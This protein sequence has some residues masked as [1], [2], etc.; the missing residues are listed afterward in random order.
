NHQSTAFSVLRLYHSETTGRLSCRFA[1]CPQKATCLNRRREAASKGWFQR[2]L[3]ACSMMSKSE[4]AMYSHARC[5]IKRRLRN[6][7]AGTRRPYSMGRST[8][9]D[10]LI[11]T[12]FGALYTTCNSTSSL[13]SAACN[14][15]KKGA[16]YCL[17]TA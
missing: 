9:S 17:T 1:P 16:L 5:R 8:Q 14:C 11:S 7:S 15:S 12:A 6:H 13:H 4:L 3:F 10:R 2:Y